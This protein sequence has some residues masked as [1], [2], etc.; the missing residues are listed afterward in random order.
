MSYLDDRLH[1]TAPCAM[2]CFT[3]AIFLSARPTSFPFPLSSRDVRDHDADRSSYFAC[4]LRRLLPVRFAVLRNPHSHAGYH[5][6]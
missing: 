6:W 4:T 3:L 5:I 2:A 1:T